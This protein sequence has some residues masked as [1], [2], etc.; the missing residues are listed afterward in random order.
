MA[1]FFVTLPLSELK[2]PGKPARHR[3]VNSFRGNKA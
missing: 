2:F 1:D 3:F